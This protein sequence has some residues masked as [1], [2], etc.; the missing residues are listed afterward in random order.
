MCPV[1]LGCPWSVLHCTHYPLLSPYQLLRKG[2]SFATF[3]S[4]FIPAVMEWGQRSVAASSG[5]IL[6]K[7]IECLGSRTGPLQM[8]KGE[9]ALTER[10]SSCLPQPGILRHRLGH[11][12]PKEGPRKGKVTESRFIWG[13]WCLS[14]HGASRDW[15]NIQYVWGE[16]QGYS[17]DSGLGTL[18]IRGSPSLFTE[19]YRAAKV[20]PGQ[21]RT[22]PIQGSFC[23]AE[24]KG[25]GR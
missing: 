23:C 6:M 20:L 13:E 5:P 16:S 14:W 12:A 7:E 25:L 8:A 9:P 15:K 4:A 19:G 3:F 21:P 17:R 18:L 11:G 10:A 22:D 1:S 24:W 2:S